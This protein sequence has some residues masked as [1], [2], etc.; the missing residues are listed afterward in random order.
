MDSWLASQA[1][2]GGDFRMTS[3]K[4][5]SGRFIWKRRPIVPEILTV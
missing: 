3:F 5:V 4:K 2:A 1:L